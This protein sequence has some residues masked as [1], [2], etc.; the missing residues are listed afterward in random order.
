MQ[1]VYK[2][3]NREKSGKFECSLEDQDKEFNQKQEKVREFWI[4]LRFD[5]KIRNDQT[6]L[7]DSYTRSS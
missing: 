5:S 1:G 2:A 3:E 7:F 4:V 6:E